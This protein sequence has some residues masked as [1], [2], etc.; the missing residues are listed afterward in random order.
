MPGPA[1]FRVVVV[2]DDRRSADM[3]ARSLE[4]AGYAARPAYGGEAALEL[5]DSFRPRV[6]LIDLSMPVMDGEH[7]AREAAKRS[8]GITLIALSGVR[9]DSRSVLEA[10]FSHYLRKPVSAD[11]VIDLLAGERMRDGDES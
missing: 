5:L 3:M 4:V 11:V 10:G 7:L 9:G 1:E 6:M 8:P 2:D